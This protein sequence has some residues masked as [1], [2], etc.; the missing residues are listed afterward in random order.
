MVV[1]LLQLPK[2]L[3][4][5]LTDCGMT[6]DDIPVELK[7]AKPMEVT[8]LGILTNIKLAH[9]SKALSPIDV[10]DSGIVIDAKLGHAKKV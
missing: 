10:T 1:K 6:T 3:Y 5:K 2:E 8:E 7:A 4:T 9:P